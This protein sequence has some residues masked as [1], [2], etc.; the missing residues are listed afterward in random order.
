[1]AGGRLE[2]SVAARLVFLHRE[3]VGQKV[4][5]RWYCIRLHSLFARVSALLLCSFKGIEPYQDLRAVALE[6]LLHDRVV[7]SP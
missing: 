4:V 1:M 7:E 6:L 2:E 5:A 3:Q